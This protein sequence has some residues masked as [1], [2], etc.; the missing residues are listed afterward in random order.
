MNLECIFMDEDLY[1]TMKIEEFHEL[2]AP[3]YNDFKNLL[4]EAFTY[5]DK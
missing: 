2:N 4:K 3:V 1:H 5:C